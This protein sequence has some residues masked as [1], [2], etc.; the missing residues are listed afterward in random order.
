MGTPAAI[1]STTAS[2]NGSAGAGARRSPARPNSSATC[3]VEPVKVTPWTPFAAA[4]RLEGF[5]L[6]P[7]SDD[8]QRPALVV[9]SAPRRHV[10][11][12]VIVS[13]S[14]SSLCRTSTTRFSGFQRSGDRGTP[15]LITTSGRRSR[16]LATNSLIAI[17]R[18]SVA[19]DPR[20]QEAAGARRAPVRSEVTRADDRCAV[21]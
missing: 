17:S 11:S 1:A 9:P 5:P 15:F 7:A 13:F 8:A 16:R 12:A 20:R 2:P 21:E 3:V 18:A 6:G 14:G 10:R 19:R 4:H